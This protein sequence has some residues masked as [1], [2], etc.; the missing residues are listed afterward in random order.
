MDFAEF[1][2]DG[3]QEDNI[4]GVRRMWKVLRKSFTEE[5]PKK[6]AVT[7]GEIITSPLIRL[8]A[9]FVPAAYVVPEGTKVFDFE[10]TG[11]AGSMQWKHGIA[12]VTA[13]HDKDIVKEIMKDMNAPAVYFMETTEG[14]INVVG[15]SNKGLVPNIK[16]TSGKSG[17]DQR[18]NTIVAEENGFRWPVLPLME[19][20][21]RQ[22]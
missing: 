10:L 8:P 9:G 1:L 17:Q 12:F 5:W 22:L 2:A 18:G 3:A 21:G 20:V 13:G 19:S 16:G 6:S 7:T 11:K 14:N 4:A 15:T